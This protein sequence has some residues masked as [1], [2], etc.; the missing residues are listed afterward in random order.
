MSSQFIAK[1]TGMGK[2][3]LFICKMKDQS[4][5]KG[6]TNRRSEELGVASLAANLHSSSCLL[7]RGPLVVG[8]QLPEENG[9][10][11]PSP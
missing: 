4:G 9:S 7:K 2:R 11:E 5:P 10:V 8:Y 3:E 1:E 6:R